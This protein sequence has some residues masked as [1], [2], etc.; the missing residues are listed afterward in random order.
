M[1]VVVVI[2]VVAVP[3]TVLNEPLFQYARIVNK[4]EQQKLFNNPKQ[5]NIIKL[6]F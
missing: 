4:H 2:G 3:D 1:V 5:A 6:V